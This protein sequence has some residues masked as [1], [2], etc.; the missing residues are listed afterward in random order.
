MG[1]VL[2]PDNFEALPANQFF[3]VVSQYLLSF[4]FNMIAVTFVLSV[5]VDQFEVIRKAFSKLKASPDAPVVWLHLPSPALS[6]MV[7]TGRRLLPRQRLWF[8]ASQVFQMRPLHGANSPSH[9]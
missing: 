3:A 6:V 9:H 1:R 5:L 4:V 8:W 7:L 2:H